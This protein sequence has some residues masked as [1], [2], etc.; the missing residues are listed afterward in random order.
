M[1]LHSY[2]REAIATRTLSVVRE[3]F[4]HR[5]MK[6][7]PH[8]DVLSYRLPFAPGLS[9]WQSIRGHG[10]QES[11]L[12]GEGITADHH[13]SMTMLEVCS[14]NSGLTAFPFHNRR[15]APRGACRPPYNTMQ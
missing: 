10:A 5:R 14:G 12:E 8:D 9:A 3:I 13:Y 15:G 2:A 4:M 7:A 11:M 1:A 6:T